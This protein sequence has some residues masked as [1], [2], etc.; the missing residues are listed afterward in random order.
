M[1][2]FNRNFCDRRDVIYLEEKNKIIM[3][4]A[5]H[6]GFKKWTNIYIYIYFSSQEI[7]NE[8]ILIV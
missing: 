2:N 5:G 8:Q 7:R 6:V 3:K 1:E 4:N